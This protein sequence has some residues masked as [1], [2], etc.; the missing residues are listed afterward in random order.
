MSF[1]ATMMCISALGFILMN[2][3]ARMWETPRFTYFC[4]FLL[5]CIP[6]ANVVGCLMYAMFIMSELKAT[7]RLMDWLERPIFRI[8]SK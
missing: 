7:K 5:C 1:F 8:Q 3:H 6:G 2:I 4:G